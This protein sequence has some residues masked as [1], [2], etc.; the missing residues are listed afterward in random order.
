VK[1]DIWSDVACPWCYIGKRRFEEGARR[2]GVPV[3]VEYHSFELSPDTPVEYAG[4]TA[5]FLAERKGL[6]LPQVQ[7]MLEQ[8]TALAA[9]EGLSYDFDRVVH[10]NTVLAHEL[11]HVAKARGRQ[12]EVAE[13]LFRAYFEEG[14]HVGRIDDLVEL[15]AEAGLDAASTRATL[16]SHE[17]LGAVQADQARPRRTASRRS[18]SS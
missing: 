12:L 18:R 4:G 2:A 7:R 16:E 8:V 14:R 5:S 11:L 17:Y 13:A 10:T 9:R 6:P 15:A 3:E 1:I